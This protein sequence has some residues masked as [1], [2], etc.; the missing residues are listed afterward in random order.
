MLDKDF[1]KLF[2][3]KLGETQSFQTA[4]EDW[5]QLLPMLEQHKV[6]VIPYRVYLI[7]ATVAM[8][9]LA[10]AYTLYRLDSSESQLQDIRANLSE[11]SE[12]LAAVQKASIIANNVAVETSQTSANA[13]LTPVPVVRKNRTIV[14]NVQTSTNPQAIAVANKPVP[15]KKPFV[16]SENSS[17]A[18]VPIWT[19][20]RF[21]APSRV[22][23]APSAS[24]GLRFQLG[25]L[26]KKTFSSKKNDTVKSATDFTASQ[27][28]LLNRVLD[29]NEVQKAQKE[30]QIALNNKPKNVIIATDAGTPDAFDQEKHLIEDKEEEN[31]RQ[32]YS[33]FS[34]AGVNVGAVVG[35]GLLG[36]KF[37]KP[38]DNNDILEG[39]IN[40]GLRIEFDFA[41][42]LR[43][44]SDL[45]YMNINRWTNDF[46]VTD[47]PDI[48]SP[49]PEYVLDAVVL[50]QTF[51]QYTLGMKYFFEA[52][53][54][55]QPFLGSGFSS[56]LTAHQKYKYN[57]LNAI[58][59]ETAETDLETK[60][61]S[62]IYNTVNINAG[63]EYNLSK[64]F[65]LQLE[66]Y[67]NTNIKKEST[68]I[69]NLYGLKASVLYNI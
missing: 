1:D 58:T 13:T 68:S 43:L 33:T 69:P 66:G 61:R 52:G 18:F 39:A 12:Q 5:E 57:Y 60:D 31:R 59:S 42:D 56:Q 16:F 4:S 65:M 7:A 32:W 17:L 15:K 14:E 54:A 50:N 46:V 35:S 26:G 25:A 49:G 6:R 41:G 34:L 62:F 47:I 63:V 19:G 10:N 11:Q 23:A 29:Y 20:K 44:F 67:Y 53:G 36:N 51:Y 40:T 45:E 21:S 30:A 27:K 22:N 2:G 37:M 38:T 64:D 55:W 3:E 28:E 24:D 48:E 9:L 8:L